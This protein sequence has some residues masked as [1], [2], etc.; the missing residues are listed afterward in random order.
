LAEE[1]RHESLKYEIILG[2]D[3]NTKA[4]IVAV[5]PGSSKQLAEAY[6]VFLNES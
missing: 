4:Q 3:K 2:V 5:S 1:K 6:G